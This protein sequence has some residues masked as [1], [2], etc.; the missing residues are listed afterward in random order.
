MNDESV[1]RVVRDFVKSQTDIIIDRYSSDGGNADLYFG[2][3]KIF[4]D[5]V[6]LKFY[7]VDVNKIAHDEPKILRQI[8]H[9][10]ILK[11]YDARLIADKYAYILTPEIV[12]GG[13][14]SDNK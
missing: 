7:Y 11:I 4:D 6:C 8:K 9:D 2:R 5:R 1:P 12:G 13:F 10:N 14:A 3:H